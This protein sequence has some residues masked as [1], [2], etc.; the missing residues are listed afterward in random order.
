MGDFE[1][2]SFLSAELSEPCL[3]L[4][5]KTECRFNRLGFNVRNTYK[6]THLFQKMSQYEYHTRETDKSSSGIDR[7]SIYGQPPR[8]LY[9]GTCHSL[10]RSS[11]EEYVRHGV[12]TTGIKMNEDPVVAITEARRSPLRKHDLPEVLILDNE[13]MNAE[14]K[15]DGTSWWIHKLPR[16]CFLSVSA[17][18]QLVQRNDRRELYLWEHMVR[19]RSDLILTASREYILRENVRLF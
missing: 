12:L 3:L 2:V 7:K 9:C 18:P 4:L 10:I 14:P 16:Y 13:K 19:F 5:R 17:E 8:I 11:C 6:A 15:M 1:V